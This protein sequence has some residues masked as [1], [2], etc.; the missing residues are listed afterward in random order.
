VSET[1]AVSRSRS[2]TPDWEA[3]SQFTS[4]LRN[5][6]RLAALVDT[7]VN[8]Y[9]SDVWRRY[10]DEAGRADE[11]LE[12]EYDYFL[13]ACGAEYPDVQRLLTWDR[14]RAAELAVAM[15]GDDPIKRRPLEEASAAWTSPTG[16][17]LVEVAA[18]QGWT[19]ATG[20][21]RVS[22]APARARTLAR[23][24]MTMD[25]HARREREELIPARRRRELDRRARNLAGELSEIELRYLR[26]KISSALA[27][28]RRRSA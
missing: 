1:R 16:L 4:D 19:T 24:G 13:I 28:G 6:S 26:D 22:P 21:L 9:E 27:R 7:V 17:S 23:H 12:H 18:R 8:M 5:A 3:I 2:H 25:E 20:R 15:A 11:W 10:T 14:A